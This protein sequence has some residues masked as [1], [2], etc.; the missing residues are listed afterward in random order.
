MQEVV[1]PFDGKVIETVTGKDGQ[2]WIS[3]RSVCQ[4]IG[5]DPN[6]QRRKIESDGRLRRGHM[7]SHDTIGRSQQMFC[8]N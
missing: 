6:R 5:I 2:P 1:M 4:A 8:I 3:V 7:S